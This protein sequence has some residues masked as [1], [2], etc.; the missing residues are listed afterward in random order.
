[1]TDLYIARAE[2]AL[3]DRVQT[4]ETRRAR[5]YAWVA[6]AVARAVVSWLDRH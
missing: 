5:A 1:M 6:I 3:T 4:G 2:S